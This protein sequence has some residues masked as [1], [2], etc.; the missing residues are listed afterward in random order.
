VAPFQLDNFMALD[1]ML[2]VLDNSL[3]VSVHVQIHRLE[4]QLKFSLPPSKATHLILPLR[5]Q[6]SFEDFQNEQVQSRQQYRV[7]AQHDDALLPVEVL[8]HQVETSDH[9]LSD[10][11]ADRVIFCK[12]KLE[13]ASDVGNMKV[14]NG[15]RSIENAHFPVLENSRKSSSGMGW[16]LLTMV[17]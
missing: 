3:D 5:D 13:L 15:R 12:M 4:Q 6:A 16:N 7:F 14:P 11:V 9:I 1:V 17:T 2:V 8:L 10:V